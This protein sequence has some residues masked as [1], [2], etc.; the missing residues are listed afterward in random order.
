MREAVMGKVELA[1]QPEMENILA[2]IKKAIHDET[3]GD[4]ARVRSLER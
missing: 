1:A 2:S 3:G 4:S